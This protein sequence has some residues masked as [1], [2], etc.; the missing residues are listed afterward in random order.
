MGFRH[1]VMLSHPSPALAAQPLLQCR[2]RALPS[3]AGSVWLCFPAELGGLSC[4][5]RPHF[6]AWGLFCPAPSSPQWHVFWQ[7]LH[8]R[9]PQAH[10]PP[11]LAESRGCCLF[12]LCKQ[13][14]SPEHIQIKRELVPAVGLSRTP[15]LMTAHQ[16]F[17]SP[18][19]E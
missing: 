2:A 4:S 18:E 12:F 10:P 7:T 19:I 3:S 9:W 16:P 14:N 15:H 17:P 5:P 1:W 13:V 6:Q 11:P 8:L